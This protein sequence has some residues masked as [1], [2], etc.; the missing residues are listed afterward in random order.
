MALAILKKKEKE[1]K[2]KEKE[3]KKEEEGRINCENCSKNTVKY[4]EINRRPLGA[5]H[6][7]PQTP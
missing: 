5:S 4:D 1:K 3:K 2:E 6:F 7:H